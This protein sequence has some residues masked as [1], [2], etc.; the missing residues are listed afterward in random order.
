MLGPSS[1]AFELRYKSGKPREPEGRALRSTNDNYII[2]PM[3]LNPHQSAGRS[4]KNN[5]SRHNVFKPE[6]S[7]EL[8]IG[9][10]RVASSSRIEGQT[11]SSF[12]GLKLGVVGS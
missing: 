9:Q 6:M 7:L 8:R 4:P 5:P 3:S 12:R 11:D 2:Q 10:G 1:G